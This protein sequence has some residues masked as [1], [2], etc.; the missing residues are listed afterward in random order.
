MNPRTATAAAALALPLLLTGCTSDGSS[1]AT[2]GPTGT[3]PVVQLGA[4]GEPNRTVGADDLDDLTKTP[5][6]SEGDIAF[7]RDMVPHHEQA[8]AMTALVRSND[9][10]PDVKLMAERME[11]SQRDEVAQLAAWLEEQGPLPPDDHTRR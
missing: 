1:E 10:S 11:I 2:P 6:A 9:A 3:A 7:V 5:E 8:L 4:P